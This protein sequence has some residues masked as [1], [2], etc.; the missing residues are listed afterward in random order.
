MT[1]PAATFASAAAVVLADA[2]EHDPVR[3][4]HLGVHTYDDRLPDPSAA[5]EDNRLRDVRSA[6]AALD[7]LPTEDIGEPDAIDAEILRTALASELVAH[8]QLLEAQWNPMMHNPGRGIA[9]LLEREFAPLAD[10]LFSVAG[11]LRATPGYLAAARA[12][13]DGPIPRLHAETALAQFRGTLA[14]LDSAVPAA[15]AQA[16]A[17]GAAQA[18]QGLA[19][20]LADARAA[21]LEHLRWLETVQAAATGVARLGPERF[22]AKLWLTLDTPMDA[23]TLLARAH[24][25][26]DR[27]SEQ[28][29]AEAGRLAGAARADAG[30]VR[31][32]LDRLAGDAPTGA[33]ILPGAR[34][35]LHDAIVFTRDR[36]LVTVP[37]ELEAMIEVIEMP[38]I[39]RGVAVAHCR[40]PGALETAPL[41]TFFAVSP[42]PASWSPQRVESFY[43]EYNSHMLYD[44]AVHEG[45]PG[46]ALQMSH[47]RRYRGNTDVRRAYWSGTFTE[48]WA[49]YAE[50]LVAD[51]G[52]R[53]DASGALAGAL[54]MQQLKMQLR[55]IINA[56]LD[57]RFHTGELAEGEAMT[58]MTER[59]FQEE[60]EAAGKWRRVQLTSTQLSTYY[61]GYLEVRDAIADLRAARPGASER[62]LHDEALSHGTVAPRHLREALQL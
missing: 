47:A 40:P 59:G 2:L 31:E 61:V 4:S 27:V 16:L 24:G 3:A 14:M 41:P 20:P 55:M 42:A 53:A 57:V 28:I 10:R 51:H 62:K 15:A 49:V 43:R 8:T 37:E 6:L 39:D 11:R 13:L 29:V 19:Q 26:L 35:A 22:A 32:V 46:H 25:D 17:R 54:R 23:P 44:L 58:L 52:F 45:V 48:G 18:A 36:G 7:S 9:V 1:D 30:T 34:T 33:T 56:I 50:E 60:G 5:A 38:E 12:R 21:V